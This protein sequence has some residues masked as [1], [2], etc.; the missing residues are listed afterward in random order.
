MDDKN[1]SLDDLIGASGS[2]PLVINSSGGN[3]KK[4]LYTI[5]ILLVILFIIALGVIAFLGGRYFGNSGNQQVSKAPVVKSVQTEVPVNKNITT[6]KVAQVVTTNNT[7]NKKVDDSTVKELESLVAEETPKPVKT[8][9]V[10]KDSS[11]ATAAS[12]AAGGKSLSQEDLAKIAKLVAQELAKANTSAQTKTKKSSVSNSQ[13]TTLMSQLS[14]AQTDTLQNE[15]VSSKNLKDVKANQS[16]KKV[17]TFNKV[18]IKQNSGGDDELAKLSSEIDAI[19]Q[20]EE[21]KKEEKNFKYK[22]AL[23]QDVKEREK[24]LRFI[25]VKKGDTL[26]SLAYKAYGR[27]SA[28]TKIYEANPGLVKNP[29]RIYVG[30]KLRVP[31]DE[32]Y[33]KQ[34]GN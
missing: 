18:I 5:L 12:A 24:E 14:N 23:E 11:I 32:E 9:A 10:K 16:A 27:A 20:T 15:Q 3:D 4:F 13:D 6:T 31:V 33:I 7:S 28:Y 8:E 17:D 25:V 21:V 29:N 19:L 30:M 1:R 26:S 22:K 34:Q 2:E